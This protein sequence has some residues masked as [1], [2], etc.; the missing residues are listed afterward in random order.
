MDPSLRRERATISRS[1]SSNISSINSNNSNNSNSINSSNSINTNIL[2]ASKRRWTLRMVSTTGWN[3]ADTRLLPLESF[4][5]QLFFFLLLQNCW[6]WILLQLDQNRDEGGR[7]SSAGCRSAGIFGGQLQLRAT[8]PPG[9]GETGIWCR[10]A[11]S[12]RSAESLASAQAL[13][14]N[15]GDSAQPRNSFVCFRRPT[16]LAPES[17][18]GK[19]SAQLQPSVV[20]QRMDQRE[21]SSGN[22]PTGKS[23]GWKLRAARWL[24]R[25]QSWWF[26]T[27]RITGNWQS[28]EHPQLRWIQWE[29]IGVDSDGS[30]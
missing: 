12:G 15:D 19:P 24:R 18:A 4:Y 27:R 1:N 10:S 23:S 16:G 25:S 8:H 7:I 28:F 11:G 20:Q 30:C 9:S 21:L 6:R 14:G 26:C 5:C 17:I 22:Y 3:W 2:A 29:N 13:P